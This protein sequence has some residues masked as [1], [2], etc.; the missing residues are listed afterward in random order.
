MSDVMP[1]CLEPE[2][3]DIPEEAQA[4]ASADFGEVNEAFANRLVEFAGARD[5]LLALDLG[6]G[7]ADIPI[8]VLERRRG[9]HIVAADISWSM[10]GIAH[11]A[12]RKKGVAG[13]ISLIQLD[14]KTLPF[15]DRCFDVVFSNSILHHLP[16][17]GHFWSEVGRVAKVGA[18]ILLRDLARPASREMAAE[19]VQKYS[20]N[21]SALLQ[22]EFFRSLL[23]AFTPDE[24]RA[25]LAQAGLDR[26][27]VA[28]VSDRHWDV[29]GQLRA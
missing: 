20:G 5:R 19:I 25:Q 10:L 11:G 4:Y 15:P 28:M 23:A 29:F 8:R 18:Y 9:W 1:R 7:P 17:T 12:V 6:T 2:A 3:M 24:L 26:L 22:E 16:E 21:E 14:S 13:G 27:D